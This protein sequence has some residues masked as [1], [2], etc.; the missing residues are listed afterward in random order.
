MEGFIG[1]RGLIDPD[2]LRALSARSDRRGW[3]Q[4]LSH[5]AAI[6]V[7]GTALWWTWGGWAAVP[8]FM[9]HGVLINFLYAGQHELSHSTV[10]RTRRLNE[11]FGR[12]IG[13]LMLYPRDFDQLQHFAHHRHTQDW[14]RDGE[15]ARE[16]Y[17]LSSYLN[18]MIGPSYWVTRVAR[19]FRFTS[20]RVIE[21]YIKPDEHELI[22][23]E[24]RW[25]L[26]LYAVIAAISIFT[27]SFA[28]VLYWLAPMIIMKPVHQMQNTM[29]H[30]GLTHKPGTM[31]N[32]RTVRTNAVVRWLGWNMAYHTAHHT[33]PAI[34]FHALPALHR[35]IVAKTGVEPNTMT[36][37]GFQLAAIKALS[38]GKSEADYSDD[39]RW[40]FEAPA[41]Q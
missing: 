26:A 29:E 20:G 8:V 28:A 32:T 11:I 10:F 34:P 33:F 39:D 30:L 6:G 41:G 25:H 1:R 3:L 19:I 9:V 7:S 15:L 14:D 12:I 27:V 13:F 31:E 18:W 21:P 36:Y 37:L 17:T 23:A 5:L 35:E 4:M 38:G 40:I 24:G 2:R 22:I 16:P